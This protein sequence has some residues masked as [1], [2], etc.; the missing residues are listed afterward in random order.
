MIKI[1]N[2]VLVAKKKKKFFE[3]H[4]AKF[5][6]KMKRNSKI[7]KMQREGKEY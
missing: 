5:S 6:K 7:K 2:N 1:Y 4:T 3:S